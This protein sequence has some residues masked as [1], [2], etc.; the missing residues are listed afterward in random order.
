MHEVVKV[1]SMTAPDGRPYK[2]CAAVMPA[3]WFS[4]NPVYCLRSKYIYE[5]SP[6]QTYYTIG[7]EHLMQK[8]EAA[9]SLW[10]HLIH[11]YL[12]LASPILP[13]PQCGLEG[14]LASRAHDAT[15][16]P[17]TARCRVK[18]YTP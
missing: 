12:K 8:N 4:V 18:D 5:H 13:A 15:S 3:T 10:C 2:E 17:Q 7:K 6:P 9:A 11:R 1:V 14:Q 16:R